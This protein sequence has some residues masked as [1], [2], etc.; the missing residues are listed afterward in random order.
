MQATKS[1][2]DAESD[3]RL[4]DALFGESGG[5]SVLGARLS[6]ELRRLGWQLPAEALLRPGATLALTITYNPRS[7][8]NPNNNPNLNCSPSPSLF[9]SPNPV[10]NQ[11]Q[12]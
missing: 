11:A 10:P 1:Q 8:P 12:P 6:F 4:M 9:R 7:S 2:L 5:S 3:A